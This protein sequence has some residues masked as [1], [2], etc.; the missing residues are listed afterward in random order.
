[1]RRL[2]FCRGHINGHDDSRSVH[3]DGK[4]AHNIKHRRGA[5]SLSIDARGDRS[6]TDGVQIPARPVVQQLGM[7]TPWAWP[8]SVLYFLGFVNES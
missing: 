3:G 5:V 6:P 1:M 2:R 4:L 7:P 8:M